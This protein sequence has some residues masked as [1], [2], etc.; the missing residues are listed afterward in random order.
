M[1]YLQY[2]VIAQKYPSDYQSFFY[3]MHIAL[4]LNYWNTPK[5]SQMEFERR[6]NVTDTVNH[7]QIFCFKY[8]L[9]LFVFYFSLWNI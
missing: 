1:Y 3:G 9:N 8:V 5:Y 4:F 6:Q 2:L 7:N